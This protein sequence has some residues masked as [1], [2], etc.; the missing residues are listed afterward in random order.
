M[1]VARHTPDR[2]TTTRPDSPGRR[3][4]DRVTHHDDPTIRL[5]LRAQRIDGIVRRARVVH[6]VGTTITGALFFQAPSAGPTFS[7]LALIPGW[8]YILAAPLF[9]AGVIGLW[10]HFARCHESLVR[11]AMQVA[12]FWYLMFAA[13]FV[14]VWVAWLI[15]FALPV[16]RVGPAPA[17]YPVGVYGALGTL[18]LLHVSALEHLGSDREC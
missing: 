12:A 2:R 1:G 13:L 4:T 9:A 6:M 14:F 11:R 18:L 3:R 7:L 8:P 15:G 16:G 10:F 17:V 5:I